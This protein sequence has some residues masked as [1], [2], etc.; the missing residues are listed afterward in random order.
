[1]SYRAA[2]V[3]LA[4][5]MG[6]RMQSGINKVYLSIQQRSMIDYSFE[7]V[8]ACPSVTEIVLVT[9]PE[10]ADRVERLLQPIDGG[11]R[12]RGTN[13]GAT[14]HE[15]ERAGIDALRAEIEEGEIDV[16]A[17]HDGARPF[18]SLDLLGRVLDE[19]AASGGA[20][21]ACPVE[22]ALYAL[23][24]EDFVDSSEYV[25]SQT[26]QAFAAR[27]ILAA[28]DAARDAGFEGVDTAEVVATFSDQPIKVV[29]GEPRNVKVTFREDLASAEAS[30]PAW[31]PGGWR[32]QPG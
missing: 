18:M 11:P 10:D 12:I 6:A 13:G 30:A 2:V 16:I 26:P 3:L 8:I 5:G 20:I 19:A 4:G 27:V 9:R 28:H 17:V 1:M 23:D 24:I 25:W 32:D 14:R 15:S 22:D 21:P 7:T 31:R 29:P